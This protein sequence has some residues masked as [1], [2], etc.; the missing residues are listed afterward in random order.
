MEPLQTSYT[1]ELDA[2][3]EGMKANSEHSN[4][5]SRVV[6]NAAGIGFG[7]VA[8]Q[9]TADSQIVPSKAGGIFRGIT[10]L[11]TTQLQDSYP[12]YGM[13]AVMTWGVIV[14]RVATAVKAGDDVTYTAATGALGTA[15]VAAGVVAIPNAVW[16]TSASAGGLAKLRLQ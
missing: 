10:I 7:K 12:Q 5:I 2:Y 4:H 14:V 9:G 1:S 11:D 13:A 8:M 16:D 15:A 6:E 3:I